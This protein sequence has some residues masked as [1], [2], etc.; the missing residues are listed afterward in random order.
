LIYSYFVHEFKS[1]IWNAIS[2]LSFEDTSICWD[3]LGQKDL[4]CELMLES[5]R[6]M[7]YSLVVMKTPVKNGIVQKKLLPFLSESHTSVQ[8][9]HCQSL[10]LWLGTTQCLNS[11]GEQRKI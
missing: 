3:F 5:K 7:F 2:G 6:S 1:G 9:D 10:Y 8:N 11:M 4:Y